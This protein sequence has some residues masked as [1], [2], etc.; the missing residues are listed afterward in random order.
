MSIRNSSQ[1]QEFGFVQEAFDHKW[2]Y[3]CFYPQDARQK[4]TSQ[5]ALWS[6]YCLLKDGRWSI[7]S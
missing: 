2:Y 5:A 7:F 1:A 6:P 3:M 4:K